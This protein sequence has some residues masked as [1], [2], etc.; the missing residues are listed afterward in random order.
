MASVYRGR[1][2]LKAVLSRNVARP[3]MPIPL[4]I[5]CIH[6]TPHLP[7]HIAIEIIAHDVGADERI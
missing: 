7:F 1:T 4:P 5:V 6:R 3:A 2:T